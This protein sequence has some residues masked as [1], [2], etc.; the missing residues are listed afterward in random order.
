M[1]RAGF[2]AAYRACY[3]DLCLVAASAAG[4]SAAEDVVQQAAITALARLDRFTDG[5]SFKA[6]MATIVRNAARNHRRGER[7]EGDRRLRLAGMGR[8]RARGESPAPERGL[9][10]KIE[11]AISTLPDRQR[12]ALLLRTVREHDYAV[13][14][15]LLGVPENTCRSDVLRARRAL[16]SALEGQR[17]TSPSA[18]AGG[19]R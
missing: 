6:W 4:R 18:G 19:A 8:G 16:A 2:E 5:T 15:E 12:E 14:A 11:E 7:R 10:P 9:D 13:I 1:D 17:A 3:G